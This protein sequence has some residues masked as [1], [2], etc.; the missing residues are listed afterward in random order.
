LGRSWRA[1]AESRSSDKPLFSRNPVRGTLVEILLGSGFSQLNAFDAQFDLVASKG[2]AGAELMADIYRA[3]SSK[4]F[5][6]VMSAAESLEGNLV[7]SSAIFF[8][9]PFTL[10]I[11][12][13]VM[14]SLMAAL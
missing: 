12:L 5:E 8:F 11:L 6:H 1:L 13:T 14:T 9:L 2:M 4:Y 7:A 3:I 10:V